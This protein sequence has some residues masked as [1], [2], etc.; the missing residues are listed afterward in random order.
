MKVL[1]YIYKMCFGPLT[2]IFHWGP[3][4]AIGIIKLVSGMTIHCCGMWWPST[5][6]GGLLNTLSFT[7]LA[8]LTLYNFL[9]AMFLGP[10]FLPKGWQPDNKENTGNLQWCSVCEGFKAPRSHHCRRCGRCVLKM[11]HHCPWINNC[12]GW[13]N[14]GHFTYFL[15]F[16]TLGCS[17]ATV[18]LSC[19]LY[20][21]FYRLHYLYYG[22]G[23]E[24]IVV[25]GLIGKIL[26]VFGLGFS[27]GVV[28]AVGLLLFF[29]V[30]GI[31]RNRTGVEDWILEK[32]QYRRRNSS[33]K[34]IFP[35]NVGI[36]NNFWQVLNLS[37]QPHGNGIEWPVVEGCDQYTLTREQIEQKREKR[38]RTK[39]YQII[40]P[41]S[42]SYFPIS[43][44]LRTC[45]NFP[46][47]DE[48]RIKLNV[49]DIVLVTRWRTHWLF[50]EKVPTDQN[51]DRIRGW[52][53]RTCAKEVEN[54]RRKEE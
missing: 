34:F 32:A 11:D 40:E 18:V 14:H 10:G 12:V 3:L 8:G 36:I 52:F 47:T 6:F 20:R 46:C 37:C 24:P 54:K 51:S 2:R 53:P 17:H 44:G 25:L 39:V 19:S 21:S 23:K 48:P 15:L 41:S 31:L 1:I 29:Q 4:T 13:G 38:M 28:I 26:T 43:K 22:T 42:G 27:I 30:R 45:M 33:T 7:S 49:G 5:T 9:S 35:Y 50:G 16:A